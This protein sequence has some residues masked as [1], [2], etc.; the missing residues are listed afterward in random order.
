MVLEIGLKSGLRKSDTL[1]PCQ[2]CLLMNKPFISLSSAIVLILGLATV[3]S[4]S[5][6]TDTLICSYNLSNCFQN[7]T[8]CIKNVQINLFQ[9]SGVT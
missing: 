6:V 7:G 4:A 5:D 9:I 1:V 3:V 8:W 2:V